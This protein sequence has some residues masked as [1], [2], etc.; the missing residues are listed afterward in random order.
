MNN[1][2]KNNAIINN[3]DSVSFMEINYIWL[4]NAFGIRIRIKEI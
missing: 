4:I 2:G 1:N 3:I